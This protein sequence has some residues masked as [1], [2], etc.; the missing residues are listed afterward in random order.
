MLQKGETTLFLDFIALYRFVLV[1]TACV[2]KFTNIFRV[3]FILFYDSR[4]VILI[5]YDRLRN[6]R[7]NAFIF[8]LMFCPLSM[9]FSRLHS[10]GADVFCTVSFWRPGFLAL[11][12][13]CA[14]LHWHQFN[15]FTI[16]I[17][18]FCEQS[19]VTFRMPLH[20]ELKCYYENG[21]VTEY[22]FL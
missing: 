17:I 1:Q 7:G 4:I 20:V 8:T 3:R 14:K 21:Q 6:L 15:V 16:G 22:I 19:S 10:F 9:F 18:F 13:F 2:N 5:T 11:I 12:R